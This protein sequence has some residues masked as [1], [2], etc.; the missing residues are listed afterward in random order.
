MWEILSSPPYQVLTFLQ[1]HEARTL[2]VKKKS[3]WFPGSVGKKAAVREYRRE[4]SELASTFALVGELGGTGVSPTSL[5]WGL[6]HP[7]GDTVGSEPD[8]ATDWGKKERRNPSLFKFPSRN[9]L[10]AHKIWWIL[11]PLLPATCLSTSLS[12]DCPCWSFSLSLVGTPSPDSLGG[13]SADS[14]S[15]S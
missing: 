15:P 6:H 7:L 3:W 14:P 9:D 11:A 2:L 12:L 8:S 5:L 4:R 13:A 1:P 10:V